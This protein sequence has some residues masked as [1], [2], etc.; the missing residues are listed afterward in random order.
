MM[1]HHA[2]CICRES[3]LCVCLAMSVRHADARASVCRLLTEGDTFA[4]ALEDATGRSDLLHALHCPGEPAAPAAAGLGHFKVVDMKPRTGASLLIDCKHTAV[5]LEVRNAPSL[6][7][8]ALE[9][10]QM[11]Q[12]GCW[13]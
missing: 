9:S 13:H 4:A 7:S 2:S 8:H 3:H 1:H 6:A 12:H 10:G 5:M 11:K